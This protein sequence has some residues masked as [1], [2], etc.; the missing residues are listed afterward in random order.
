MT[1]VHRA[2]CVDWHCFSNDCT[3][4]T[5]IVFI[6]CVIYGAVRGNTH[7]LLWHV[8][9]MLYITPFPADPDCLRL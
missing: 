8:H 9:T 2:T 7:N 5:H 6:L 1:Q 4:N 3:V